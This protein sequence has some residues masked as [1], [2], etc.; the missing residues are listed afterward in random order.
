MNHIGW[1]TFLHIVKLN[2]K[3]DILHKL[4]QQY[5]MKSSTIKLYMR[6][7]SIWL[8]VDSS[9]Y[10]LPHRWNNIKYRFMVM[11]MHINSCHALRHRVRLIWVLHT[12]VFS[13]YLYICYLLLCH[14]L[15]KLLDADIPKICGSFIMPYSV[16]DWSSAC[17]ICSH[18][19]SRALPHRKC[20]Q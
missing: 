14:V 7:L 3:I 13:T 2:F 10:T 6:K 1:K 4:Q 17:I 19:F 12:K 11:T 18:N 9:S 16:K 5:S 15:H 20:S 8:A